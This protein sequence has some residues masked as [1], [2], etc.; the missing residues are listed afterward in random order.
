MPERG[1]EFFAGCRA[2]VHRVAA[3]MFSPDEADDLTQEVMLRLVRHLPDL[4]LDQPLE[5][6]LATVTRTVGIPGTGIFSVISHC[7]GLIDRGVRFARGA[8]M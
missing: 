7:E 6:W 5:P 4:D 8:R 1:D 3:R 2:F